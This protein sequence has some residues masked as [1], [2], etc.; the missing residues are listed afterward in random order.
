MKRAGLSCTSTM[1][2][3]MFLLVLLTKGWLVP[4][5]VEATVS[6]DDVRAAAEK[7]AE[8]PLYTNVYFPPEYSS[9]RPSHVP[10]L[11]VVG[12]VAFI[13]IGSLMHVMTEEHHVAA[14]W[15][16]DQTNDV[17]FYKSFKTDG[18]EL[19]SA[20]F[21]LPENSVALTPYAHCNTHSVWA[22]PTYFPV[23]EGTAASL[24]AANT[25]PGL[26]TA[27]YFPIGF[28]G[29]APT[30]VPVLTVSGMT[31]ILAVASIYQLMHEP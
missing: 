4:N 13:T 3:P 15:V 6:V 5:H 8:L 24:V 17:I 26:Y 31:G 16:R 9:E 22:G 25:R 11:R 27:T 18:T 12:S 21:T 28:D 10:V 1:R 2:R 19:P 23:W 29:L 7:E 14:A 30:H 20:N